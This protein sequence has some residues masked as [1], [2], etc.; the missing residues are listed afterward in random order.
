VKSESDLVPEKVLKAG[1][2]IDAT[3]TARSVGEILELVVGCPEG[4]AVLVYEGAD[5]K[6]DFEL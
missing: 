4:H 1:E 2:S 5:A 3:A 6:R